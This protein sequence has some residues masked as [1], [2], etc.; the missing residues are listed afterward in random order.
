MTLHFSPQASSEIQR[1]YDNPLPETLAERIEG[2]LGLL[3]ADPGNARVRRHRM[4]E[5]KLWAIPVYGSKTEF[6]ILW[7]LHNGEPFVRYAGDPFMKTP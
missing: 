5:P 2:V 4:Q 6:V 7:D 3:E 1:V